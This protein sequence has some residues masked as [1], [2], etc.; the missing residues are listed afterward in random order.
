[1]TR[2]SRTPTN[3]RSLFSE[4]DTRCTSGK[5]ALTVRH[6]IIG[7]K[8]GWGGGGG[9]E[10]RGAR[11]GGGGNILIYLVYSSGEISCCKMTF[12]RRL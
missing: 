4:R 9:R 6:I 10:T 1:M 3:G 8:G 12:V 11:G 7:D 5:L 2:F